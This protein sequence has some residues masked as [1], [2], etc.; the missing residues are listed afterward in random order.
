MM[1]ISP[2]DL[3]PDE[4]SALIAN[5]A[6]TYREGP[7]QQQATSALA[8]GV[9][10][11]LRLTQ[12]TAVSNRDLHHR[13]TPGDLNR[14]PG[15]LPARGVLNGIAAQFVSNAERIVARWPIRQ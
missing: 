6:G 12:A 11:Y 1:G 15:A 9:L 3:R 8:I 10:D 13:P 14:E 7:H 5:K 4:S 2:G